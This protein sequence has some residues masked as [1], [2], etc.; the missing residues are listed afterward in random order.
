MVE[1]IDSVTV[2]DL[3]S[4]SSFAN[5][6]GEDIVSLRYIGKDY[7]DEAWEALDLEKKRGFFFYLKKNYKCFYLGW[8]LNGLFFRR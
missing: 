1:T 2:T 7:G 4:S 6:V 3:E 5:N 8:F